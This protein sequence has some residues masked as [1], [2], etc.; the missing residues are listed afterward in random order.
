MLKH[1]QKP[2]LPGKTDHLFT[3]IRKK[4]GLTQEQ[5]AAMLGISRSTVAH[6]ETGRFSSSSEANIMLANM[7]IH[8][9]ELEEGK[10]PA[11]RS[12]EARLFLNAEYR[13]LLPGIA[14]QEKDCRSKMIALKDQLAEMKERARDAEHAIIV[15]TKAI[16]DVKN[17][18]K[19]DAKTE[20][21]LTGLHYWKEQAYN[22][23]FSCWEPAQAVLQAR[24]K[25]LAGEAEALRSYRLE[26]IR[27]HDP[28]KKRKD[29]RA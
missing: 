23:L 3:E 26:V 9:L 2:K 17:L 25:A 16:S 29:R 19:Q 1:H 7:Y 4:L 15:F 6:I 12:P 28:F 10:Q 5:A 22:R 8:F 13:E 27:E 20:L 11:G 21:K 14:K 18:D 24:I